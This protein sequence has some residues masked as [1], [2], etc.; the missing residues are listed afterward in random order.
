[1]TAQF[2]RKYLCLPGT[3]SCGDS[4]AEAFPGHSWSTA[5]VLACFLEVLFFF[6][7]DLPILF[8]PLLSQNE[9]RCSGG[10]ASSSRGV[11]AAKVEFSTQFNCVS[12]KSGFL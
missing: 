10:G 5:H 8:Y 4:C 1:M 9:T 3:F 11:F 2:M 12:V 6:F 7:L